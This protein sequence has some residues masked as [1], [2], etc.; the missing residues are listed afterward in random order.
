MNLESLRKEIDAIDDQM[1]DLF[2]KR[3]TISQAI[4]NIKKELKLPVL[5]SSREKNILEKRKAALKNENLWPLYESFLKHL[6][7]LSKEHQR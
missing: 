6:F 4:G 7:E 2:V 1:M 3:M 5:D